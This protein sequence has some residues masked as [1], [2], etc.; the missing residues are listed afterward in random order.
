MNIEQ[1]RNYLDRINRLFSDISENDQSTSQ[2]ERDLLKEYVRRLYEALSE[3]S[4]GITE[5]KTSAQVPSLTTS[6][7]KEP[8]VQAPKPRIVAPVEDLERISSQASPAFSFE[9]V[10]AQPKAK[11]A[12]IHV[13]D[14]QAPVA[15]QPKIIQ[16]PEEVEADI[17]QTERYQASTP[18]PQP[19]VE[20]SAPAQPIAQVKVE[21]SPFTPAPSAIDPKLRELFAI[22]RSND[23]SERLAGA[24]IQDLTKALAINERML[25]QND[26]FGSDK[27]AFET[28]LNHLNTLSNYDDAVSFLAGGAALKYDWADEER[29]PTA[30]AFAKLVRRRYPY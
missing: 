5:V 13:E 9:N 25:T 4:T 30:R 19:V 14:R 18:K 29:R 21:E 3:K 2:L 6:N 12:A 22:E 10:P 27:S 15:P 7:Q 20:Q 8:A 24:P 26:L 28:A 16:I 23:L 17:V 1:A 11:A